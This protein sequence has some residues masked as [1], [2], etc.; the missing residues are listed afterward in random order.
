[1]EKRGEIDNAIEHMIRQCI[2]Q[3]IF[4]SRCYS[5]RYFAICCLFFLSSEI[6]LCICLF[7]AFSRN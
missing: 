4:S 3:C 1:M 2:S 7:L 5:R 6:L